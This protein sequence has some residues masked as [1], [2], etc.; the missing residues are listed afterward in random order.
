[1]TNPLHD[2]ITATHDR[3]VERLDL[4]ATAMADQVGSREIVQKAD[5]FLVNTCRHTAA[6]C[7]LLLP[8]ARRL[9]P[10]GQQRVQEYVQQC[11]RMERTFVRAKQRLY[12][13]AH[14]AATPWSE[15]WAAAIREFEALISIERSLVADLASAPAAASA[16]VLSGIR[17]TT[18]HSPT[19]PHPNSPHTGPLSHVVRGLWA[20]ADRVWDAAEGRI[21]TDRP[22]PEVDDEVQDLAS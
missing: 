12:G 20:R 14:H 11:R 22:V 5:A 8:L 7:D 2:H 19:R 16:R 18:D 15:I 3:L 21:V 13:E 1:M 9:L 4:A 10:D 6:V 17:A